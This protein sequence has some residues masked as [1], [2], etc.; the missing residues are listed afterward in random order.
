MHDV[1]FWE[2]FKGFDHLA[3]VDEG[4]LFGEGPLLLHEFIKSS[5]I[6]EFVDEVKVVYS[7]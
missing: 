4:S 1:I 6:A 5:A 7:L 2:D 3:K